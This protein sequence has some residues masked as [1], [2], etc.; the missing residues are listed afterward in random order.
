MHLLY[1]CIGIGIG[2]LPRNGLCDV[3]ELITMATN[4]DTQNGQLTAQPIGY[5]KSVEGVVVSKN[6]VTQQFRILQPGD[7]VYAEE[8]IANSA[9]FATVSLSSG[10]EVPIA[11]GTVVV[12]KD[13]GGFGKLSILAP[14][15]SA[16]DLMSEHSQ[17]ILSESNIFPTELLPFR[18]LFSPMN[19]TFITVSN[20]SADDVIFILPNDNNR[21]ELPFF[22]GPNL[23]GTPIPTTPPTI[24][25]NG[26]VPG[27]GFNTNFTEGGGAVGVSDAGSATIMDPDSTNL[28]SLSVR[29]I[30]LQD[31]ASESL[32]ANVGGTTIVKNYDAGTGT[33]TLSG[34]DSLMNYQ[35]VLRTVTY[36]NTS[37]NPVTVNRN[38]E[39][40]ANDGA[41]TSNTAVTQVLINSVNDPPILD[42]DASTGGSNFLASF[43]EDGGAVTIANNDAFITD[44]DSTTLSS[45]TISITNLLDGAAEVLDANVGGTSIAKSYDSGTGILTLSGVDSIANY[46]QVLRTVTY[47]NTSQDPDTTSRII[48]FV[49]ND[50]SD[51]SNT[52][53]STVSVTS[54]ND[55]PIIDLDADNSSGAGGSNYQTSFTEDS[56]A[57]VVADSDASIIDIDTATL[58]SLTVAF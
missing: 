26:G 6:P 20:L 32:D 11:S 51:N 48:N 55:A 8:I 45:L 30:N 23:D 46:Q 49:A 22:G 38:I 42:L 13:L 33:L 16:D 50:G 15:S 54:N 57:V 39:F 2:G 14:V 53:T 58:S 29:I 31:G 4:N 1:L 10:K 56:G 47:N 7:P 12:A 34:T 40:V 35:L 24:D 36:N 52:A 28:S 3:F 5:M 27:T 9:G 19:E 41:N 21:D 43:A 44:I 18:Q 25:L 17:P 37:H